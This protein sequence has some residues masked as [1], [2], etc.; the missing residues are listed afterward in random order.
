MSTPDPT[1]SSS[2]PGDLCDTLS[3]PLSQ[4]MTLLGRRWAGMV[5]SALMQGPLHFNEVKRAVPGVSDRVLT[6]RL[7]EFVDL[8]LVSRTVSDGGP[9]RVRYELTERGAAM[10]PAITELTRWAEQNLSPSNGV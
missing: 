8:G 3:E 10:R 9:V 6:E 4:V 2:T 7:G 5:L 1:L